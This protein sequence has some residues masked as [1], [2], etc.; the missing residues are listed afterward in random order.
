MTPKDALGVFVRAIGLLIVAY[1]L[2]DEL[3]A[4][5]E[6][7]GF[8]PNAHYP[9]SVHGCYGILFFLIGAVIV[10]LADPIARLAYWS[11][12]DDT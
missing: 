8:A 5:L 9:A 11:H 3:F 12:T 2:Y 7:W 10:R 4:A 1:A 6:M